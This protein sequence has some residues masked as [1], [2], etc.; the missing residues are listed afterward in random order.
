MLAGILEH[1]EW[2][3]FALIL[4]NQAGLPVFAA[5]ALLG[6][7]ALLAADGHGRMAVLLAVAVG[8]ALAADLAWY[9]LGRWR[10]VGALATL[11][12]LSRGT[13]VLVDR[14]QRLFLAHE[15]TVQLGARFLPELNPVAATF[16]GA[17]RVSLRRFIVRAVAS[18]VVWAATWI[19]IGCLIGSAPRN[20]VV[21]DT[22]HISVMGEILESPIAYEL[23]LEE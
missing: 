14:A 1:A 10:G 4:A 2:V 17:A 15:G 9:A 12:R 21:L 8:A 19:S 13:G 5:P 20:A 22:S 3:V 7:G 16:A 6:V 18:A 23:V 11:G